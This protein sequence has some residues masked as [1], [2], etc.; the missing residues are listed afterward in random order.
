MDKETIIKK[1]QALL[2]DPPEK[3]LIL[4]KVGHEERALDL[5]RK[6][7]ASAS[8][9]AETRDADHIASAADR[10]NFPKDI[11]AKVDFAKDPVL[12]HPLSGKEFRIPASAL[13]AISGVDY[14]QVMSHVDEALSE[15]ISKY[16]DTEARYL[17]LWGELQ[18]I[19]RAKENGRSA[20]GYLWELLP[21]D[22]R[23]PDH[24]IWEHRRVVS[25]IAGALPEPSLLLFSIGPVQD[26]I[27]TA[28]KTQD[29]WAGSYLLSYISWNAMKVVSDEIGP[30]SI[31]FPDLIDQPFCK[32]WL[33]EKG[34]RFIHQPDPEELSSPTLPNRFLAILPNE[35][36]EDIARSSEGAVKTVFKEVCLSVKRKV[37]DKV[38]DLRGD[39]KWDRIWERQTEDFLEV[40]WAVLPIGRKDDY[41]VFIETYK[42]LLGDGSLK[43]F[44]KLIKEY[45][46]KGFNPNIGTMYGNLYRLLEK[47]LGSRKITRDFS[48]QSEPHYKCTVCGVREPVHPEKHNNQ[49][50]DEYGALVGFWRERL[51]GELNDIKPNERLCAVCTTKRFAGKFHFNDKL[52]FDI[53]TFFPSTSTMAT[54]AFKLRLI[55]SGDNGLL[56]RAHH[57]ARKICDLIG[58]SAALGKAPPMV[59][60]ACKHNLLLEEFAKLEGDW[61]YKESLDKKSLEQ[62]YAEDKEI[63]EERFKAAQK[64]FKGFEDALKEMEKTRNLDIGSPSSYYAIIQMDGDNM[65]KWLSGEL[66][67]EIASILHPAIR[68]KLREDKNWQNLLTLKRP[69]NPSLHIATSRALRDFSLSVAREIIERD[70][71]GKL[72]YSGGD[73][74]LAFVSLKDLPEVMHCLRAYFSGSLVYDEIE[75][76]MIDFENGSGFI[77]VDE[78]GIP[79]SLKTKKKPKGFLYAMG[80]TATAS[81]GVAIVHH[82]YDLSKAL[83]E[84]RQA[85]KKAKDEFGKNAF[86]ISL[87]KRSGGAEIFGGKWYYEED[88][89]FEMIPVFEKVIEA[90]SSEKGISP[91]FA[92]DFQGELLGLNQDK[93]PDVA[94]GSEIAR[95]AIRH[96]HKEFP[97]DKARGLAADLLRLKKNRVPLDAISKLLMISAFLARGEN[98]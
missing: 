64:A 84:V 46:N 47:G 93:L 15:I 82:S 91:K 79:L 85:E 52:Q 24:S 13:S 44:E 88:G 58:D 1:I 36:A 74:V 87:N 76:V 89:R 66:A 97:E 18:Q 55:E 70:Y 32:N 90:F 17:A 45:E 72:I 28:R 51:R 20:L 25:A 95:L 5:M 2:H 7:D 73:D 6:I 78:G 34:M 41:R 96:K 43:D 27:A 60:R 83:Q 8:I 68:N 3:A 69:L 59:I 94:V 92:Y 31:I 22:S 19:I 54:A 26:F 98:Q 81:M 38:C 37:E 50:C 53:R 57:Y 14:K 29:L 63:F 10:I 35:K 11:E 71:L 23:I 4:G 61:F 67:P 49:S 9:T 48:Q 56:V 65:G 80:T 42:A 40:Y 30:D 16:A 62:E 39:P 33:R 21:A 77:P 75:G 86:C 12:V